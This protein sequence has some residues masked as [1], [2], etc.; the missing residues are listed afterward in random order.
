[1]KSIIGYIVVIA[2]LGVLTLFNQQTSEAS[3]KA[4]SLAN[5]AYYANATT[6][7]I[8]HFG[9]R[10]LNLKGKSEKRVV[11][12]TDNNKLAVWPERVLK[13]KHRNF[14]LA[15]AFAIKTDEYK[16]EMGKVLT[17]SDDF[18]VFAADDE[19]KFDGFV[20]TENKLP[21]VINETNGELGV[22][23]GNVIIRVKS[24]EVA[25]LVASILKSEIVS[26]NDLKKTA[27]LK[28]P[29]GQDMTEL[30][31]AIRNHQGVE[32]ADFQIATKGT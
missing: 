15:Q 8:N 29:L 20:A 10:A 4:R 32:S 14:L 12:A 7:S 24:P 16:A 26:V 23:T 30:M 3:D 25:G 11:A 2:A 17:K 13:V 1:M 19:S 9:S 31:H 18:V 6:A 5:S 21:V 27:T 22:V 28:L